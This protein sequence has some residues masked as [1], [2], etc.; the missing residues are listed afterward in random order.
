[1][2]IV[3]NLFQLNQIKLRPEQ[4]KYL[5]IDL[6]INWL[7]MLSNSKSNARQSSSNKTSAELD[8]TAP[9]DHMSIKCCIVSNVSSYNKYMK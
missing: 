8:I 9:Y 2:L 4:H 3:L 6:L 7:P 5:G 1:M